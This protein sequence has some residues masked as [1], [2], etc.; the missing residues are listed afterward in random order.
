MWGGKRPR[1]ASAAFLN[2]DQRDSL[3]LLLVVGFCVRLVRV[4]IVGACQGA[5]ICMVSLWWRSNL[6]EK[7]CVIGVKNV[8][9]MLVTCEG[10]IIYLGNVQWYLRGGACC[11]TTG[12]CVGV[13]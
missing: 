4:V 11:P 1:I 6:R 13:L 3:L 10:F 2:G 5:D 7:K 8:C 9:G 12:V